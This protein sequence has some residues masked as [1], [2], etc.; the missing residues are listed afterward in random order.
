MSCDA[1]WLAELPPAQAFVEPAVS[2]RSVRGRVGARVDLR[3]DRSP[4]EWSAVLHQAHTAD[5]WLP[6]ALGIGR[7][8]LLAPGV[9]YQ[10]VD[11][12]LFGGLFH[13]RRQS[14]VNVEWLADGD[15]VRTCWTAVDPGP[16]RQT[17]APW[18]TGAAYQE[19][20][21]ATGGWDVER[22]PDGGVR[23]SYQVWADDQTVVPGVQEWAMSWT[24]PT[25]IRA[26][27]ERVATVAGSGG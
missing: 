21:K 25:M 19:A 10:A 27:A 3:S 17:L 11:V 16:W 1:G 12:P 8:E 9:L 4:A 23:A 14:V 20:G 22:L 18:D 13:F 26:Y 5:D 15:R 6:P 2:T 7:A 24:L